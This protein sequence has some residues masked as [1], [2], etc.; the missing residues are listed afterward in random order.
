MILSHGDSPAKGGNGD[1]FGSYPD[2]EGQTESFT[3]L[4]GGVYLVL[5][6]HHEIQTQ[7]LFPF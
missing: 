7:V 1:V 5:H 2:Y 6:S 3:I 4:Y